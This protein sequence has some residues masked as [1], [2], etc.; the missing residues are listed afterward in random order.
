MGVRISISK[1][2]IAT[3]NFPGGGFG[4]PAPPLDPCVQL[5]KCEPANN[6]FECGQCQ[7]LCL[8][9]LYFKI[10]SLLSFYKS[11]LL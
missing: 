10:S 8:P 7:Y 9:A 4:T 5:Y 11:F 2:T 6:F 1:E 3:C